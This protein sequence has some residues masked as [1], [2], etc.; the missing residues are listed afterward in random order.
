L[1][2]VPHCLVQRVEAQ[3]TPDGPWVID[4]VGLEY[5]RVPAGYERQPL[6]VVQCLWRVDAGQVDNASID[7][8]RQETAGREDA[9]VA[10]RSSMARSIS[11]TS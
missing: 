4:L 2:P 1:V 11:P 7:D 9:R 10:L 3:G 8:V 5:A 6:I